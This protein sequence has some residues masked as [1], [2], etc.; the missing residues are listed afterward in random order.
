M[1]DRFS[2]ICQTLA[3]TAS[4]GVPGTAQNYTIYIAAGGGFAN[5]VPATNVGVQRPVALATDPAG[6]LYV[7]TLTSAY[8]VDNAG[9]LTVLAETSADAI[10]VDSAG[11]VYIANGGCIVQKVVNGVLIPFAGNGT[12]GFSGDHGLAVNAELYPVV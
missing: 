3:L 1:Q 12:C 6:N 2:W 9:V 7:G 11:N 4:L 5:Q 8:K 10:A